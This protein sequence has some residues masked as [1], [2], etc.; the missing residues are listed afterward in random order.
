MTTDDA[1]NLILQAVGPL[2]IC[3]HQRAA[4]TAVLTQLVEDE[5]EQYAEVCDTLASE[6]R[7]W[8]SV[9]NCEDTADAERYAAARLETAARRIREGEGNGQAAPIPTHDHGGEA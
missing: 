9:S 2:V 6:C 5:R 7:G 4:L 1:A 8:A 3:S